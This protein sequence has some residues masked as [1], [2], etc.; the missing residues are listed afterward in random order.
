MIGFEE[1]IEST[2]KGAGRLVTLRG[3]AGLGFFI[4]MLAEY[5]SSGALVSFG[6]AVQRGKNPPFS[7]KECCCGCGK[8]LFKAG[9]TALTKQSISGLGFVL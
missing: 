6:C 1:M 3:G 2:R 9:D 7:D 8:T 5:P 4:L